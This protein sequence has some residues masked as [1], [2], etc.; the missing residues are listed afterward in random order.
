MDHHLIIQGLFAIVGGLTIL[1]LSSKLSQLKIALPISLVSITLLCK[2]L[3]P[4]FFS[5]LH[6]GDYADTMLMLALALILLPDA[7]ALEFKDIKRHSFSI[8]YLAFISVILSIVVGMIFNFV[9][10]SQYAFT[11][12]ATISLL[13]IVLP[14][15][16]ISVANVFSNFKLPHDLKFH[17]EGES[18][19]ND[20]TAVIAFY[21]VGLPLMLG[22]S[23]SFV[24]VSITVSKVLFISSFIG[25]L[26]G[27]LIHLI[28]KVFHSEV[29]ELILILISAYLA[30]TL[31][32]LFH[33]SGILAMVASTITLKVFIE[34]DIN[35]LK[36]KRKSSSV[37]R[38]KYN[39]KIIMTMAQFA[40]ALI[41]ISM[42][43]IID[44]NN[45]IL[46]WKEIIM[47][48]LAT[49]I[50]RAIMMFK[51]SFITTKVNKM[52]TINKR[53]WF[54]L[55][56]SGIKGAL[57]IVMVHSIPETFEYKEMFESMV[58]GVI[59]LSTTLYSG[60]LTIFINK[61]KKA[62]EAETS[63]EH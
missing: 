1:L 36:T 57:S 47:L 33:L 35:S 22:G 31:G 3:F 43:T 52:H 60:I 49:T 45:L 14:T 32:E 26:I 11:L 5:H 62:F 16:A 50:I 7:L 18:L 38:M 17:A 42:A 58:I 37:V 48:F 23:F 24:D 20:A 53:W 28:M 21:F 34:K 30:F 59:I 2:F 51:F 56:F 13:A 40:T 8:F 54:V 55:T 61:N 9:L 29:E 10:F 12:G 19:A 4:D 15:D 63:R 41:F 27:Y 39:E 46:Y 6:L 44:F 25:I